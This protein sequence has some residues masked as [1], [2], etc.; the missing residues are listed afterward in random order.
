MEE[1]FNGCE[2][3]GE[4]GELVLGDALFGGGDE[5]RGL[6]GVALDEVEAGE[7]E[8]GGGETFGAGVKLGEVAACFGMVIGGV[9]VVPMMI[10]ASEAEVGI[11]HGR[12]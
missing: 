8:F 10:D 11:G 2:V 3:V 12:F 7:E 6:V 9:E 1:L 4:G 5:G